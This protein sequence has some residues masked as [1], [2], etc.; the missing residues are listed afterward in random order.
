MKQR[1]DM[2]LAPS[3]VAPQERL[4]D[5]PELQNL[6]AQ[7]K[8]TD[9]WR[10]LTYWLWEQD[11]TDGSGFRKVADKVKN[12]LPDV[13]L[14]RP[15]RTLT[16]PSQVDLSYIQNG[17]EYDISASG[18][19]LRTFVTLAIALE[20]NSSS[21]LLFDEP[22]SHL[23]S[24]IQRGIADMLLDSA[25]DDR[26]IVISTHSPDMINHLPI[27]NIVWIDRS[28]TQGVR[29]DNVGAIL[30]ELGVTSNTSAITMQGRDIL[31]FVEGKIDRVAYEKLFEKC[32]YRAI[33]KR[34]RFEESDGYGMIEKLKA[35]ANVLEPIS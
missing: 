13:T 27:K 1:A 30:T 24:S 28:G 18:S 32:G 9:Y 23:H 2:I 16:Q 25:T 12:Y 11:T 3:L 21:L 19:G 35:A 5:Y 20:L 34:V 22:D 17:I 10:N 14:K 8:Y 15:R 29:T 4:V 7:G 6:I 26:Q 31:L 33:L